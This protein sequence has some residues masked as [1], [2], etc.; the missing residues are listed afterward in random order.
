MNMNQREKKILDIIFQDI[1]QSNKSYST[2]TNYQISQQI[3]CSES[4]TRDK[5]HNLVKKNYLQRV[6]NFWSE[7]GEF[8]NR[9]LY[10]GKPII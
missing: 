2:L 1:T 3:G 4:I 5:I 10:K 6:I 8:H 7:D 9:V